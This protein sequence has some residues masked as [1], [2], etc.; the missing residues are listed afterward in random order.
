MIYELRIEGHLDEHWSAWFGGLAVVREDDGTTTL[1]GALADQAE[2]HGILTKI[3]DLGTTL[4]S[5]ET[6]RD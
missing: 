4:I 2:L 5:L 3:R 1:R 6:V